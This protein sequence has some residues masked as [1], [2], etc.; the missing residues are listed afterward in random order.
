M[1][2]KILGYCFLEVI[3]LPLI[4]VRKWIQCLRLELEEGLEIQEY[5]FL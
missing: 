1:G 2:R 5:D 3:E 4:E